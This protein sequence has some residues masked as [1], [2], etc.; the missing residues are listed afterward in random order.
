MSFEGAST[1]A[2]SPE[3]RAEHIGRAF[4]LIAAVAK[5]DA[6]SADLIHPEDVVAGLREQG[7]DSLDLMVEVL[8]RAARQATGKNGA[9]QPIDIRRFAQSTPKEVAER[10]QHRVPLVPFVLNGT[11]YDPEDINRFDGRELHF[12]AG[13]SRNELVAFDDRNVIARF[14]EHTYVA[15]MAGALA[16]P[17]VGNI[18]PQ[19]T[20][21][22]LAGPEEWPGGWS[23]WPECDDGPGAYYYSDAAPDWGDTLY[24]PPNRGYP[25]LSKVCR[26]FLCTGDWNDV[27]SACQG[28]GIHVIA[29]YEHK[30]WAGDSYTGWS[31]SQLNWLGWNDRAS[32]VACW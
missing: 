10:I 22:F 24:C 26:G 12:V 27:I 18:A 2:A 16:G 13:S 5:G 21:T 11:L 20:T 3:A 29:M 25:Q 31:Q 32:G 17:K 7:I 30:D 8:V 4:E 15:A 23:A 14:W 1:D 19:G 9:A 6:G 28:S